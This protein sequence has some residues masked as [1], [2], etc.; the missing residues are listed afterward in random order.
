VINIIMWFRDMGCYSRRQAQT[1][2]GAER[3]ICSELALSS[4][5][6]QGLD[7]PRTVATP[8]LVPV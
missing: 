1:S 2:V 6:A 8:V 7:P 5:S 4:V 3:A